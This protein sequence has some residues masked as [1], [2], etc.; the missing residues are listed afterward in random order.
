MKKTV[1]V[2]MFQGEQLMAKVRKI[3]EGCV[4]FIV[5]CFLKHDSEFLP[6]LM[7]HIL[8]NLS[9]NCVSNETYGQF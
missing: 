1:F 7:I 6:T 8:I 4:V 5:L 9:S 3:S 2:V